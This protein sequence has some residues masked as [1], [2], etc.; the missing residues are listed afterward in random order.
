M[1]K[2]EDIEIAKRI[3]ELDLMRDKIWESLAERVGDRAYELLRIA[4]NK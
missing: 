4:Q 3:I 2:K 1:V